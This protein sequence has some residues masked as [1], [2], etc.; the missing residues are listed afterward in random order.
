MSQAFET[1]KW[2]IGS[3]ISKNEFLIVNSA[4]Q[5]RYH[6]IL[7]CFMAKRYGIGD[8][9]VFSCFPQIGS[10]RGGHGKEF[11]Y[12]DSEDFN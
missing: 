12:E 7:V 5:I 11:G 4:D 1:I 6:Q 9:G 3:L 10:W 2:L 8:K